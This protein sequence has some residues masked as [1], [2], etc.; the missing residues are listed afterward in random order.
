MLQRT[1]TSPLCSD[2]AARDVSAITCWHTVQGSRHERSK[3]TA[4]SLMR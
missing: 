1:V 3:G 2:Y 4:L